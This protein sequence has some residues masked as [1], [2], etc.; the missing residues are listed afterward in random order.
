MPMLM[1]IFFYNYPSLL[2]R[3]CYRR[4]IR[5]RYAISAA[6]VE[7]LEIRLCY[8]LFAAAFAVWRWRL[9]ASM[10]VF[11]GIIVD[12]ML[13]WL[14][15]PYSFQPN[16]SNSQCFAHSTTKTR[17]MSGCWTSFAWLLSSN[18]QTRVE[19]RAADRSA[20]FLDSCCCCS[21]WLRS[22]L[23]YAMM[24]WCRIY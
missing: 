21:L 20:V 8:W 15:L 24:V 23:V 22:P 6:A 7:A 12:E 11:S 2:Y 19:T 5:T 18:V 17:T 3:L 14:K 4:P 10:A 1:K 13:V 16:R 9:I